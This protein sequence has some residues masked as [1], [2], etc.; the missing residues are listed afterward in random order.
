MENPISS[1][2]TSWKTASYL[3][4]PVDTF[5]QIVFNC[6]MPQKHKEIYVDTTTSSPY[7]PACKIWRLVCNSITGLRPVHMIVHHTHTHTHTHIYIYIYTIQK[8]K[9]KSLIFPVI[10]DRLFFKIFDPHLQEKKRREI[11]NENLEKSTKFRSPYPTT[12]FTL[13]F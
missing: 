7:S 11:S 10:I 13:I 12:K 2:A 3:W 1:T 4:V 5:G 6:N 8:I 9:K